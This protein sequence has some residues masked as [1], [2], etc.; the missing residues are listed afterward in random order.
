M[1]VAI[2][3]VAAA[4]QKVFIAAA[5]SSTRL[6]HPWISA[7]LDNGAFNRYIAKNDGITHF[8]F[9]VFL[10][11]DGQLVGVVNL[12][13]VIYGAFRSGYLSY[14]AFAGYERQ[15][16]MWKG[17][18][19]VVRYA[20]SRLKLHRLEAN[21]QPENVASIALVRKCG[22][23]REGFSPRYLK[24]NGRWRDHER[25]A[26]VRNANHSQQ[27][28]GTVRSTIRRTS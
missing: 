27:H 15:G 4:D 7:P 11:A 13:N 17:L 5:R 1:N 21:I 9:L 19:A 14:Y 26:V 20:F 10:R 8:G 6:H 16:Y 22:F 3:P 25:W 24:I 23:T 18:L 2:R 12:T 28:A